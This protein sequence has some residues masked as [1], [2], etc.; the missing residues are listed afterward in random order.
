MASTKVY[1]KGH[2]GEIAFNMT[3]MIDCT[4]QLIIFFM[5]TTQIASADFV[6][7]KLP[8]PLKPAAKEMKEN[9]AIINVVPYSDAE[10][11]NDPSKLGLAK[12]YQV[13]QLRID[14]LAD[15]E[16]LRN[17]LKEKKARLSEAQQKKFAVEV[18]ADRRIHYSQIQPILRVLQEAELEK[19]R[20][21]ALLSGRE[22]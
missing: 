18:R 7:M 14:N 15:S 20:I 10:I 6:K 13:G 4:F 17:A 16:A 2:G 21:T 3:P 19:M 9:K 12:R 8:R 11:R 22:Q 1:K 5:L